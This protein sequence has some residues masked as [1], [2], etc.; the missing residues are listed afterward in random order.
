MPIKLLHKMTEAQVRLEAESL[1][2]EWLETLDLLPTQH[3]IL[4]GRASAVPEE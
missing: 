2:L 1:G 3:V 4:F